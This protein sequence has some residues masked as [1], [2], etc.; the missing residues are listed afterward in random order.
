MN[1]ALRRLR[2]SRSISTIA[3]SNGVSTGVDPAY[4]RESLKQRTKR[5]AHDYG[6]TFMAWWT[7]VWGASAIGIYAAIVQSGLDATDLARF[8]DAAFGTTFAFRLGNLEPRQ[9]NFALAGICTQGLAPMRL[10]FVLA[11]MPFVVRM[12]KRR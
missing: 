5:M 1:L 4:V 11:T 10:P 8:M 6:P 2:C 7:G 12:F 9:R 3:L